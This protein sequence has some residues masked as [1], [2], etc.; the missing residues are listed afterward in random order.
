MN[1]VL[2]EYISDYLKHYKLNTEI[3]NKQN[4]QN[5]WQANFNPLFCIVKYFYKNIEP[6]NL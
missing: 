2:G 4:Y 3:L 1:I 5:K 6:Q